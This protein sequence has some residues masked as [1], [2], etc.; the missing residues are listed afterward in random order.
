M[1]SM[2]MAP[3]ASLFVLTLSRATAGGA[4]YLDEP[5]LYAGPDQTRGARSSIGDCRAPVP[6]SAKFALLHRCEP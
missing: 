6:S 1:G 4:F 5:A 2:R 3:H